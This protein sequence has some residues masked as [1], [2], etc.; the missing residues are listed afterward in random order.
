MTCAVLTLYME[1]KEPWSQHLQ[2]ILECIQQLNDYLALCPKLSHV[3]NCIAFSP[4]LTV[5]F[6]KLTEDCK[7]LAATCRAESDRATVRREVLDFKDKLLAVLRVSFMS[8][9][10]FC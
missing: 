2:Y 1:K 7:E 3:C 9:C 6:T 8:F 4:T 10:H 5:L